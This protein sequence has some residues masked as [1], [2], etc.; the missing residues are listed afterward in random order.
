MRVLEWSLEWLSKGDYILEL[1]SKV[2]GQV[3][4]GSQVLE[5]T[6]DK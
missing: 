2:N 6:C 4:K 3:S 1:L 5:S